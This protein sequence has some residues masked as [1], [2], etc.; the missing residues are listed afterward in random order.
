MTAIYVPTELSKLACVCLNCMKEEEVETQEQQQ[1]FNDLPVCGYR[2]LGNTCYIN[3]PLQALICTPGFAEALLT[4]FP[5]TSDNDSCQGSVVK[6]LT[7]HLSER[8][9]LCGKSASIP[10]RRGKSP[11][12]SSIKSAS[13]VSSADVL[14]QTSKYRQPSAYN[15]KLELSPSQFVRAA[16]AKLPQFDGFEQQDASDFFRSLLQTMHDELVADSKRSHPNLVEVSQD[17]YIY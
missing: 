17:E 9:K 12:R 11:S 7:A 13:S 2:N 15:R 14:A 10:S 8:L 6:T 5:D 16:K 1:R 4:R 3:A